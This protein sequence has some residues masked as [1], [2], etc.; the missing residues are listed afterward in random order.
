[1]FCFI[2]ITSSPYFGPDPS[3]AEFQVVSVSYH[4]ATQNHP[5]LIINNFTIDTYPRFWGTL[6]ILL[7]YDNYPNLLLKITKP[8]NN[9]PNLLLKITHFSIDNSETSKFWGV[10]ARHG[11]PARFPDHRKR[12]WHAPVE[13]TLELVALWE[14]HLGRYKISTSHIYIF[15]YKYIHH[16]CICIY[17]MNYKYVYIYIYNSWK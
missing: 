11:F 4:R 7:L 5:N 12:A 6:Q 15:I 3:I 9:Y 16:V 17:T 10:P 8:I 2:L 13:T 1:M 14:I